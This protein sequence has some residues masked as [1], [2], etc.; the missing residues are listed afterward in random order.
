MLPQ[1]D[2]STNENNDDVID[3]DVANTEVITSTATSTT[4]TTTTTSS[5]SDSIATTT[6]SSSSDT[7]TSRG[8]RTMTGPIMC[9]IPSL[10]AAVEGGLSGS[11][12]TTAVMETAGSANLTDSFGGGGSSSSINNNN[13]SELDM[14]DSNDPYA[15][16]ERYLEKVKVSGRARGE[17]EIC[18]GILWVIMANF[19]Y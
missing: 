6:N 2:S 10:I 3:A 1:C 18:Y 15:E 16:L 17:T 19:K 7:T 9:K 12:A 8:D 4:T 5:C 13:A 14:I 11:P